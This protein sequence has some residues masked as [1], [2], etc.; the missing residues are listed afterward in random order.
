MFPPP[1]AAIGVPL[2]IPAL[3]RIFLGKSFGEFRLC[4]IRF[5]HFVQIVFKSNVYVKL[6]SI[7]DY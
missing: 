2:T 1:V 6:F 3:F 5:Y 4:F 7:N